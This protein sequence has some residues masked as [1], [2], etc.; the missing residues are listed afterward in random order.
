MRGLVAKNEREVTTLQKIKE[1]SEIKELIPKQSED[2]KGKQFDMKSLV[3]ILGY[4]TRSEDINEDV[5]QALEDILAKAPYYCELMV[6]VAMLL[7]IEN[8][9]GRSPK[10][11]T[12]RNI[13]TVL[14]FS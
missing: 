6:Q 9:A 8:K 11:I 12:A 7:A 14:D 2:K 10:K 1:N 13:L 4:L 5:R 3:L